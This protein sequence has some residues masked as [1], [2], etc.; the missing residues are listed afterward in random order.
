MT[1]TMT[2]A[3]AGILLSCGTSATNAA[4]STGGHVVYHLRPAT[5]QPG[6]RAIVAAA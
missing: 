3:L 6:R 1:R 4:F 2:T 5:V